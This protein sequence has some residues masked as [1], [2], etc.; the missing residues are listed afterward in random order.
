MAQPP[1]EIA[2]LLSAFECGRTC[3]TVALVQ[4]DLLDCAARYPELFPGRPFDAA[5]FGTITMANTFCAPWHSAEELRVLNRITLWNF[6]VDRLID[7]VAATADEVAD[8]IARCLAV[9]PDG[10]APV[11]DP[12]AAFLV[13]IRDELAAAPAYPYLAQVWH[14]ELR[15]MLAS[16]AREW[17][18]KDTLLATPDADPPTLDAYLDDAE[19]GFSMVYVA[20]WIRTADVTA[21]AEA[22]LPLAAGRAVQRVIRLLNDL[23]SYHRDA[24]TGDANALKLADRTVVEQ[25]IAAEIAHSERLLG[26]LTRQHPG[27]A[28]FLDRHI[29]FN[30]GF[31]RV[32]DY[33]G[34]L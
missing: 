16:M 18:R 1:A 8:I 9:V 4:R 22:D 30:S 13:E 7:Y 28:H 12:L 33:Q 3:A 11:G 21:P 17:R 27:L 6:G 25:R 15:R 31:Y 20:H 24:S 29:R 5:F 26:A 2:D 23:G 32:T 10:A 34:E 19:M 14:E